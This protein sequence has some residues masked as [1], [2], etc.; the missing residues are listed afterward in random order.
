MTRS[1]YTQWQSGTQEPR[2]YLSQH[3]DLYQVPE[4]RAELIKHL[5]FQRRLTAHLVDVI[6]YAARGWEVS[7]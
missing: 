2:L 7:R 5:N 1:L 6:Q 3:G 4:S